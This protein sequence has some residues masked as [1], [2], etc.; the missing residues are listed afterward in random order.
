MFRTVDERL[1]DIGFQKIRDDKYM[2]VYERENTK[3][4]YTQEVA[5]LHKRNNKHIIQSYDRD[6]FDSMHIGNICVGLT[7]HESKLFLKKMKEKGW[8]SK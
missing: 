5:L 7:Y 2:V 6:L 1:E 8:R 3:H 4:N